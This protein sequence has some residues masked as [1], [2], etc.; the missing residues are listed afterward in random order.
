M[1]KENKMNKIKFFGLLGMLSFAVVMF[2]TAVNAQQEPADPVKIFKDLKCNSCHSVDM[3]GIEKKNK[4]SKAPD[5]SKVGTKY[6]IPFFVEY[7]KKIA[8]KDG[9][10]HSV[11]FKG[12]EEELG[13]LA[14]WLTTLRGEAPT[15]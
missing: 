2:F 6:E 5:L 9:K 11:P 7:L 13:A 1:Y 15:E 10:K 3:L 8:D 12:T 4:G 14:G